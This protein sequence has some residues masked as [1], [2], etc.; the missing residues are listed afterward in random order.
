VQLIIYYRILQRYKKLL[1]P[2]LFRLMTELA[3]YNVTWI[4]HTG[5]SNVSSPKLRMKDIATEKLNEMW[6]DRPVRLSPLN[7]EYTF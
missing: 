2:P 3:S 6:T 4:Y 5:F 1:Y 7:E